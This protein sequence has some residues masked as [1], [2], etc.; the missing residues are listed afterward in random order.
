MNKQSKATCL[1]LDIGGANIKAAHTTSVPLTRPFAVWK[2]PDLLVE[3]LRG[4]AQD[5]PPFDILALT[6]T[7]ELCDC[8]ESKAAGV[9]HVLSAVEPLTPSDHIYIWGIDGRFDCVDTTRKNPLRAA[10]ANWLALATA[11]GLV[12]ATS[13]TLLID[14]GSTTTDL[15]PLRGGKPAARGRTDL[16]RLTTGELVYLGVD[17]TPLCAVMPQ[18]SLRGRPVHLA[19]EFFATTRD[20][21]TILGQT[22]TDAADTN[23]ADG[24]PFT[25]HAAQ[26]RLARM[27]CADQHA[28]SEAEILDLALQFAQHI[29]SRLIQAA[30]QACAPG[31]PP[32]SAVV[33]GSGSF[34]AERVAR[35]LRC[36]SIFHLDRMW[37]KHASVAACAHALLR[38]VESFGITQ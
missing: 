14:I 27:L 9:R 30:I 29:E 3:A 8:F 7:A 10:S 11:V 1:A 23:S 2:H 16:E 6:M 25:M 19:A 22:P 21:F 5:M 34:L 13:E 35:G 26:A 15:I 32:N 4:I 33:A 12:L 24:R 28:F 17:R 36:D 18:I 20:V 37:G 38:L 31:P